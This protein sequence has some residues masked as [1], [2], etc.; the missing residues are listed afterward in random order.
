ME[1]TIKIVGKSNT[2]KTKNFLFNKVEN[3]IENQESLVIIDNNLEYYNQFGQKL[4]DNNYNIKVVNF[5][6][7]LK[8]DGY[9]P[10]DYLKYLYESNKIDLCIEQIK[11][12]D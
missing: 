4:K 8:S 12:W 11:K 7:P 9:D 6:E 10:I 3:L 1:K 5:K 2:G